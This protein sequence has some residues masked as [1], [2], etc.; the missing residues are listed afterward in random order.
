MHGARHGRDAIQILYTSVCK[1]TRFSYYINLTFWNW[2]WVWIGQKFK[3]L[4]SNVKYGKDLLNSWEKTSGGES[5][6][7]LVWATLLPLAKVRD[8][9]IKTVWTS[10]QFPYRHKPECLSTTGFSIVMY[11]SIMV[12]P[13]WFWR[14]LRFLGTFL[15]ESL[16]IN[17]LF[18][19]R[20]VTPLSKFKFYSLINTSFEYDSDNQLLISFPFLFRKMKQQ[21]KLCLKP[22]WVDN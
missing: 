19:H 22:R 10:Q 4:S 2:S 15:L 6:L 9:K 1:E 3:S 14:L 11:P 7:T 17:I 13:R 21:C 16:Y 20:K 8:C 18:G 12:L 5:R